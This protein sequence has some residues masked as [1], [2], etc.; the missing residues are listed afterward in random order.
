MKI[1]RCVVECC[2]TEG[3]QAV[4]HSESAELSFSDRST[5]QH[6][7]CLLSNLKVDQRALIQPSSVYSVTQAIS[8]ISNS[9]HP[10]TDTHKYSF[11]SFNVTQSLI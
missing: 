8:S 1:Q 10:P 2:I 5:G 6:I 11:Y 7:H 9:L 3:I 4:L